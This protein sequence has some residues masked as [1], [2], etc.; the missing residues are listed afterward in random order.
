MNK[1]QTSPDL[2][3]RTPPGQRVVHNLP[4]L[5]LGIQPDIATAT[6]TLELAGAIEHPQRLNWQTFMQLPQRE[7]IA[8][9]HCVTHWTLFDVKWQG[10][11]AKEIVAL[12]CLKSEVKFVV[13]HSADGYTT[14]VPLEVLLDDDVLFAY[15]LDGEALPREHGGPVRVV[16]PKRYFWKSAKWVTA[17]YFHVEDHPGYWEI[18]GYHNEADPFQEQRYSS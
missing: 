4:V 3:A 12:A 1:P 9:I 14:N 16:V 18:R 6:W 17:I 11:A 8:D 13:L 2:A 15:Q 10:V 5:D 7:I